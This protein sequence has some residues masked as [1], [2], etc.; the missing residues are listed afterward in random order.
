MKTQLKLFFKWGIQ[1]EKAY[2]IEEKSERK[3]QYADRE[4][5]EAAVMEK[6]S[7][8]PVPVEFA[9]DYENPDAEENLSRK[10][11]PKTRKSKWYEKMKSKYPTR[12]CFLFSQILQISERDNIAALDNKLRFQHTI[13]IILYHIEGDL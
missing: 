1:F 10:H 6:Y 3:V 2:S 11:S 9:E 7:L 5:V 4:E 12:T 8:K 13:S